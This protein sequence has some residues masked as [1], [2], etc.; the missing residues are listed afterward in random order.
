M[1][2]EIEAADL[3]NTNPSQNLTLTFLDIHTIIVEKITS[4]ITGC[5]TVSSAMLMIYG[6]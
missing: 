4:M 3:I 2:D 5:N 6:F 1:N